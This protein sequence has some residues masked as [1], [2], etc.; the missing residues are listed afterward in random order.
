MQV[1]CG[2]IRGTQVR[3]LV[4]REEDLWTDLGDELVVRDDLMIL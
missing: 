3:Q 1:V 2:V 4:I